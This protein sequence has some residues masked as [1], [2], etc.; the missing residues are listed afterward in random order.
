M[1]IVTRTE[2]LGEI[3]KWCVDN[4]EEIHEVVDVAP[5][6]IRVVTGPPRPKKPKK[7]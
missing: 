1:E 7:K 2:L 6:H 4:S 3:E 5:D